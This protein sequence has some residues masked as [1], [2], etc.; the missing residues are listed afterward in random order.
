MTSEI[1]LGIDSDGTYKILDNES[2]E[3]GKL[4]ET[5]INTGKTWTLFLNDGCGLG[6]EEIEEII[7]MIRELKYSK[8]WNGESVYNPSYIN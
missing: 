2:K 5:R 6:E 7:Q 8:R 1:Y 3:I 4:E